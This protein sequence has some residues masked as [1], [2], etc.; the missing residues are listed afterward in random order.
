MAAMLASPSPRKPSEAM[1]SR[2]SARTSLLVARRARVE[3]V[4]D[5][6]F[7]NRERPFDD[8]ARR[9]LPDGR[10]VEKTYHADLYGE[11]DRLSA[12]R[13]G[14]ADRE[15]AALAR[16]AREGDRPLRA[17]DRALRDRKTEPEPFRLAAVA[18]PIE[19]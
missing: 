19:P 5:Q 10:L 2:S 14:D 15:R 12:R 4:L 16:H 3:G 18:A 9:D 6:L 17:F 1:R 13:A 7:D 8:F 11:R